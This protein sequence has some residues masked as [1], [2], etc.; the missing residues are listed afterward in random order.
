MIQYAIY[1]KLTVSKCYYFKHKLIIWMFNKRSQSLEHTQQIRIQVSFRARRLGD[2]R[3]ESKKQWA[4]R[5]DQPERRI[6]SHV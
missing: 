3:C 6:E 5:A 4:H 2:D 1:N